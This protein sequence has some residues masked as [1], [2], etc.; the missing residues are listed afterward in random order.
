MTY[1]RISPTAPATKLTIADGSIKF[2]SPYYWKWFLVD[3]HAA[4]PESDRYWDT[5]TST[6]TVSEKHL[7]VMVQLVTA[8][9]S[10]PT[11]ERVQ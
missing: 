2:E 8:S 3:L 11:V 6:W 5:G 4:V 7:D 9:Y 1:Y 10:K